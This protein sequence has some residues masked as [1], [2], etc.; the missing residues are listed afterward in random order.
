VIRL[1]PFPLANPEEVTHENERRAEDREYDSEDAGRGWHR[2]GGV[3]DGD[4]GGAPRCDR[5]RR[6]LARIVMVDV[7]NAGIGLRTA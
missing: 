7:N 6:K 3:G 2:E 1:H 5:G 4:G